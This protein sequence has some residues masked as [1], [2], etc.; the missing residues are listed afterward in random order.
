MLYVPL[1]LLLANNACSSFA[2]STNGSN[3]M[4]KTRH[5][6]CV[7]KPKSAEF[8]YTRELCNFITRAIPLEVGDQFSKHIRVTG[9]VF[10]VD[11]AGKVSN[12]RLNETSGSISRDF[13]SLYAATS[14]PPFP[15][16]A[17][18]VSTFMNVLR[19]PTGQTEIDDIRLKQSCAI[20]R[21]IGAQKIFFCLIPGTI[22]AAFP[23]TINSMEITSRSNFVGIDIEK[24]TPGGKE[25]TVDSVNKTITTNPEV[26]AFLKEWPDFYSKNPHPDHDS[27]IAF[28]DSLRKRY[29]DL[30]QVGEEP[31]APLP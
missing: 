29:G 28:A 30:I 23:G 4:P 1:L 15:K 18:P 17:T 13:W 3:D 21:K 14:C 20:S 26:S 27:I 16:N 9:L 19:N 11:K 22:P 25:W 2:A 6:S 31:E 8:L 12:V 5:E 10:D 7:G 24:L